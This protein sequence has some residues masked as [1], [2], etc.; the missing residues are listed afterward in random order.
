V[1]SDI[2]RAVPA[3]VRVFGFS[4]LAASR[5]GHSLIA[6]RLNC[7]ELGCVVDEHVFVDAATGRVATIV[8]GLTQAKLHDL[9]ATRGLRYSHRCRML[10]LLPTEPSIVWEHIRCTQT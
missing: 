8:E 4:A 2:G 9:E 10:G 5:E 6:G 3:G 7:R 1:L